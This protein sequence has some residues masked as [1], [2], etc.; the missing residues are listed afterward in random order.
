MTTDLNQ[1][2]EKPPRFLTNRVLIAIEIIAVLY[3]IFVLIMIW[4]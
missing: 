3:L 1:K 4:T 2:Q